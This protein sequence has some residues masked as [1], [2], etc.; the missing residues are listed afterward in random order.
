[1]HAQMTRLDECFTYFI[2][3][4]QLKN[5]SDR[6]IYYYNECWTYFIN[7]HHDNNNTNSLTQEVVNNYIIH[8]KSIGIS[9]ISVNTK[10]RGIRVIINYLISENLMNSVK[11]TMIKAH[12]KL[13]QT[14]TGQQLKELLKTP[15]VKQCTFAQLRNWAISNYLLG[16]GNRVSTLVRVKI[17]DLDFD[18][19][20]ININNTKGRRDSIIPMSVTLSKVL[21]KYLLYRQHKSNE[22]YLFVNVD[23]KQMNSHS[24]SKQMRKYNKNFLGAKYGSVHIYRHTFAKLW[25]KNGGDIFRLQKMLGHA[26]IETVREYVEMFAEDLKQDFERFNPLDRISAVKQQIKMPRR[27]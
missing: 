21:S 23:G 20:F 15:N 26:D 7:Y 2:R 19:L 27:R 4:C 5:L 22:E 14:F 16:T 8:L 10:L 6:T 3:H 1:M 25:I 11:V 18:N 24:L 13:K 17:S 9:D 12:K